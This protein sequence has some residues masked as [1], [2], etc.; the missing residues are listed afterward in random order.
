MTSKQTKKR[1]KKSRRRSSSKGPIGLVLVTAIAGLIVWRATSDHAEPTQ[2][3]ADKPRTSE[4]AKPSHNPQK[5]SSDVDDCAKAN[6][7]PNVQGKVTRSHYSSDGFSC[8]TVETVT[9]GK[10]HRV[11]FRVSS[12]IFSKCGGIDPNTWQLQTEPLVWPYCAYP[13]TQTVDV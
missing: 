3:H 9:G 11:M 5:S 10:K 12:D 2:A 6:G 1:H 4:S 13:N 8:L 7:N